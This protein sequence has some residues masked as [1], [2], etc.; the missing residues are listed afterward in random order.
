MSKE[1]RTKWGYD[2]KVLNYKIYG[3]K[4]RVFITPII[5]HKRGLRSSLL[6]MDIKRMRKINTENSKLSV[7]CNFLE[8]SKKV[9]NL[10]T[11]LF[12]P[13]SLY[14]FCVTSFFEWV[15]TRGPVENTAKVKSF[16]ILFWRLFYSIYTISQKVTWTLPSPPPITP[17][18]E[19][20]AFYIYIL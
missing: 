14:P 16:V 6:L 7:F 4:H 13:P 3:S 18:D 17:L 1:K 5:T 12:D 2:S 10:V 20:F 19:F 11:L 15:L 9:L 8:T